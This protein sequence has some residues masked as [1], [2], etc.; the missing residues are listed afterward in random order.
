MVWLNLLLGRNTEGNR[1]GY[2]SYSF[3]VVYGLEKMMK[4]FICFLIIFIT[5]CFSEDVESSIGKVESKR[6]YVEQHY[7]NVVKPFGERDVTEWITIIKDK[8]NGCVM[9]KSGNGSLVLVQ[10]S[11]KTEEKQK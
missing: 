2:F 4:L 8:T 6:F 1:N 9:Y 11:C 3:N 7:I 5:N 10:N